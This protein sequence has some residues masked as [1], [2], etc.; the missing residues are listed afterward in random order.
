VAVEGLI[1]EAGLAHDVGDARLERASPLDQDEGGLDEALHLVLV[2]RAALGE[3]A[4]DGASRDGAA[5]RAGLFGSETEVPGI[6]TLVLQY[7]N[8]IL[9]AR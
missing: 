6:G 2:K 1:R 9:A 3:G 7:G 8:G 4:F 5:R